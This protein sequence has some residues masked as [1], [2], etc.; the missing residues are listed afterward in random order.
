MV[1]RS[2]SRYCWP[3]PLF[4]TCMRRPLARC[5]CPHL[6]CASLVTRYLRDAFFRHLEDWC[7]PWGLHVPGSSRFGKAYD[8]ASCPPPSVELV[9]EG[10]YA[11]K[12]HCTAYRRQKKHQHYAA[13]NPAAAAVI[14]DCVLRLWSHVQ[15]RGEHL[16][17]N[18]VA[19]QKLI[20][21]WKISKMSWTSN[22]L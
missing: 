18:N 10:V 19:S 11:P 4:T 2:E 22:R 20:I 3:N 8:A 5:P 14:P 6:R 21:Q 7:S 12:T 1:V 13:D 17:S 9:F 16:D 15:L